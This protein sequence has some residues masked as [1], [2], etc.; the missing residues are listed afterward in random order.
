MRPPKPWPT[1]QELSFDIYIYIYWVCFKKVS[2][3]TCYE[4]KFSNWVCLD[5]HAWPI[6]APTKNWDLLLTLFNTTNL[7]AVSKFWIELLLESAFFEVSLL[8]CFALTFCLYT[9]GTPFWKTSIPSNS[10]WQVEF[11]FKLKSFFWLTDKNRTFCIIFNLQ[12]GFVFWSSEAN[13]SPQKPF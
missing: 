5:L 3:I 7:V 13:L 12:L 1:L 4:A 8:H 9:Y 10:F 11:N 2:K 6:G